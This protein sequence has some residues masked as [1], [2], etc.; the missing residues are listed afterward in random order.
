MSENR[1][2]LPRSPSRG[3]AI[4]VFLV[5]MFKSSLLNSREWCSTAL[6]FPTAIL[7]LV[8]TIERI[9]QFGLV[10]APSEMKGN[11]QEIP[12]ESDIWSVIM[13]FKDS[14][15]LL[16]GYL[17][18]NLNAL[19]EDIELGSLSIAVKCSS[20]QILEGLWEDYIS[21]HLNQVVQETL[22]TREVLEILG[23]KELKLKVFISDEKYHNGKLI[24][25]KIP[26]SILFFS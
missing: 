12:A 10:V 5:Y 6:F 1:L 9:P 22:V 11:Q 25:R 8:N 13:S 14:F 3:P 26:V 17:R 7:Q 20:L 21:G 16:F 19:V 15:R 23:L 18:N 24:L 4:Y 2:P